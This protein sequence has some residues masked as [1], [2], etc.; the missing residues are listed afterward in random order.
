MFK[1]ISSEWNKTIISLSIVLSLLLSIYVLS[2]P[3]GS[4]KLLFKTYDSLATFFEP[5][6]MYGSFS[7][8]VFLIFIAISKYGEIEISLENK[9]TYSMFS[10][11]SM[12]FAAGIGA[13]LLYWAT[14][15][16]IE[17]FNILKTQS[18]DLDRALLYS[19]AYPIFHWSFT[20]WAIYCLPAIA[21][22]LAIT[23]NQKSK[24]TFSGIFNTNNKFLEVIFDS[25]FVGAIL[26]G[27][28]VGLGLSFPLISSILSNVFNI[29][30]TINL[31]IFTIA[32]CL[33]IFATS[34]YL[35]IQKGI[36]R[37]SNFNIILVFT[38][39]FI[40]FILGPTQYIF[41]KSIESFVFLFRE[42]AEL[43]FATETTI[44]KD[45]TVFYWAWWMALAP[46]V[47]AFIVN[48]SNGKSLRTIILGVIFIGSMGCMISMSILSNLS[49]YLFE[50]GILNAPDLLEGGTLN[51]EQIIIRT[52]STLSYSNYL[53]IGFGVICI[54]F[55]CTTYDS[56]SYI[57]AS[58]SMKGSNIESSGN[59]R[60]I[61]A[62][63]L[64]IQPTLLMFLG[65]V[66]SFK[67]IMVIFSVPLLLIYLLLMISVIKNITA[68]KKHRY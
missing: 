19:R 33:S 9:E 46:M 52:L 22:G 27:A 53:L 40:V 44:S 57:L 42:Y 55:L 47:G 21:F 65:G 24:L 18:L 51:R 54:I 12:L 14:V 58:A 43:S 30:R 50:S 39:L 13:A 38:F 41:S 6:Y 34:A 29:E 62:I 49:I 64:V 7:V 23:I 1:E 37:L 3:V 28:G 10:W 48:I 15:E 25:L 4:S 35:G 32:I 68:I 17:Y 36:K 45:W 66:D 67:W 20:A 31:D 60:L 56:T 11:G 26:C 5:A 16:W 8:L 59:L 2:D 63:L 61:F